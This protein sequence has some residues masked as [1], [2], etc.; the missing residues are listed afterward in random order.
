MMVLQLCKVDFWIPWV[1]IYSVVLFE[2]LLGHVMVYIELLEMGF[3][4]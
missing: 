1:G 3:Y 4:S 2:C